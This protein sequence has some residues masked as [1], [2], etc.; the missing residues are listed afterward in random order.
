MKLTF[1]IVALFFYYFLNA[2][3]AGT[4][5]SSFGVN[6]KVL[7]DPGD[8]YSFAID[9]AVLQQDD[10]I[11]QVGNYEPVQANFL[12]MRYMPDGSIDYNFGDS[13]KAIIEFPLDY[14]EGYAAA[15]Q[16]DGK[17]VIAGDG[18]KGMFNTVSYGLI[19]RLN[20]DG[21]IDS[22]FGKN[23]W[24]KNN[25]S[26]DVSFYT[27]L[28]QPDG[29]IVAAG[30]S[31]SYYAIISRYLPDGTP[32]VSFG[33]QGN[34]DIQGS[35]SCS[36]LQSN[37]DIICGG[38]T[39]NKFNPNFLVLRFLSNGSLDNS[40]G[41]NGEAVTSYN[42]SGE[43]IF[44]LKISADDKITAGG[45]NNDGR[46]TDFAVARFNSNGSLDSS[47][48]NTGKTTIILNDTGSECSSV[49]LQKDGKIL[50]A[51]SND[52]NNNQDGD[53]ALIRLRSNGSVDSSFGYN[54]LTTTDFAEQDFGNSVFLQHSGKIIVA[55][56]SWYP[57]FDAS[58]ARYNND[59]LS[60][61]Q[62]IVQKIKHYIQTHNDARATTLNTISIYPN[63]AQNI[64][65]V[66]GLSSSQKTTLTVVDFNGNIIVS[67]ELSPVP[68]NTGVV[69]NGYDLNVSSLHAGN[70]LLKIEMN[71]EVVTRQFVKE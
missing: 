62:I 14:A 1:T 10:K 67:R 64:L 71:G 39:T 59:D 13:G 15:M 54:G 49:A 21:S 26:N 23:G 4:L 42:Q 28:I 20:P 65:H 17:I 5:D 45:L 47:F 40:F 52:F 44:D 12:A 36:G 58:L 34:S 16:P 2:Q 55:G 25:Y 46:Q 61:K 66:E 22:S 3:K 50:L 51:G 35:I 69:N 6:G 38:W 29:K 18:Y 11:I 41:I 43:Q 70:Y 31:G 37:G 48:A 30:I 24:I 60:K 27:V 57:D 63:P 56:A 33:V 8:Y 32:D 9:K 19:A 53:Y 7:I 68:S